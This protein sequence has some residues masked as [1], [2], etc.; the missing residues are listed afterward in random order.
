MET[1]SKK[2][3]YLHAKTVYSRNMETKSRIPYE[4]T[5]FSLRLISK[6]KFRP[7]D[8]WDQSGFGGATDE[9]L[10]PDEDEAFGRMIDELRDQFEQFE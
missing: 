8:F 4:E 3:D 2:V 9:H 5:D 1:K 6:I 7:R 10:Y